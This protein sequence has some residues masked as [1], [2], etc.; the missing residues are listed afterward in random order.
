MTPLARP[1]EPGGALAA[2][3]DG[4]AKLTLVGLV[5]YSLVSPAFLN[6]VGIPYDVPGG[7]ILWKLHP[8]TY[9]IGLAHL[10]FLMQDNPL[11][12]AVR[13]FGE[14]PA[15]GLLG[16]VATMLLVY[17]NLRY[18]PSGSAFVIDSLLVPVLAGFTLL[19]AS[20]E[21]RALVF[22]VLLGLTL[23]NGV[24]G[25]VEAVTQSR[26]VPYLIG[27]REVIEEF[28][29][30]TALGG[31][32]LSNSL[33]TAITLCCALLFAHRPFVVSVLIGILL[34]SLLAFGSRAAT[35]LSGAF[36]AGW[37]AL[38]LVGS[39][40]TLA[41]NYRAVLFTIVALAVVVGAVAA[42]L[43]VLNLGVRVIE[44]F[45]WDRSAN[46][47]L[48]AFLVF[49]FVSPAE[50]L[51]GVSPARIDELLTILNTK[52]ALTDIENLWILFILQFGVVAFLL[53]FGTLLAA[54]VS[55]V[56]QSPLPLK[57]AA[58]LFLI[59]I[60][61]NNSLAAKSQNLTLFM[62]ILIGGRAIH[63]LHRR[64]EE[65]PAASEAWPTVVAPTVWGPRAQPTLLRLPGQA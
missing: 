29:R 23:A 37:M 52:T 35:I 18:G 21:A 45:Y 39:V 6:W 1:A 8:G 30:A 46:S 62:A 50:L 61:S 2:P 12:T 27:D 28:F 56:R 4:P 10:W 44:T 53:L 17:S 43:A 41:L 3:A 11:R 19:G 48:L 34:M 59:L 60:S 55:L 65:A 24:I 40:R 13:A 20:V 25:I 47:R 7:L 31:H 42:G 16:V 58:L 64:K 14:R 49:D 36:L 9:V 22:R 38:R 57:M 15:L 32:P 33:R 26:V 5:I 63:E 54:I 51:I